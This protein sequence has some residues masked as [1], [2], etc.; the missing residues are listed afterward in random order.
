[1]VD[2]NKI[3]RLAADG[4]DMPDDLELPEQLLYLTLREL[5]GNFRSGHVNRDRAKRE[6]SRI[7]V[8]YYELR[9]EYDLAKQYVEVRERLKHNIGEL[10][11]CGCPN[12]RK[13]INIFTGIDREDIPQDIKE[14]HALNKRLQEMV[15]ERSERNAVL[16]TTIDRVRW[17]LEKNDIERAKEIVNEHQ[18][19][20][21]SQ[22]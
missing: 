10:Y 6:K 3:E 11:N 5:Y 4:S 7:M 14:V 16:A 20:N 18:K 12:C 9:Q 1:M 21:A 15:K 8:A 17:A 19:L 22:G 13:L 2:T